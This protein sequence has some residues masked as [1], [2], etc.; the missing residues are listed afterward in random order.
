MRSNGSATNTWLIRRSKGLISAGVQAPLG[1]ASPPNSGLLGALGDDLDARSLLSRPPE[2]E[3]PAGVFPAFVGG[4][5]SAFRGPSCPS[6]PSSRGALLLLIP[7][8][9]LLGLTLPTRH[10]VDPTASAIQKDL[11][12]S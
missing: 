11:L 10:S 7:E 2:E 6:C 4:S 5:G 12:H 9:V 3:Q 8:S 1:G